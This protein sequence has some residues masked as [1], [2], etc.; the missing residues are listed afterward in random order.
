MKKTGAG[1]TIDRHFLGK[2]L[3]NAVENVM[4]T[5]AGIAISETGG[6]TG[7][8][9]SQCN[10]ITGIMMLLG[11]NNSM[12]TISVDRQTALTIVS[13]MTG[14]EV[15][16]LQDNELCD[17][18]AEIVNMISGSAKAMLSESEYYFQITPPFVVVGGEHDIVHKSNV[19]RLFK[20]FSTGDG[21][22][23]LSLYF[24]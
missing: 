8:M 18:V 12:I 19:T 4:S 24:F 11:E 5:M 6:G 16:D 21:D 22:I 1:E 10:Q 13:Y 3:S 2:C 14:V 23:R 7:E 15:S 17:G 9:V 20:R